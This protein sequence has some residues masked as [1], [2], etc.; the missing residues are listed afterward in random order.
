MAAK[1]MKKATKGKR[2]C[3]TRAGKLKKGWK[4]SKSRK[5]FCAPAKKKAAKKG[6]RK[7]AKRS[8]AAKK[9]A[10]T[11]KARSAAHH[12]AKFPIERSRE[13]ERLDVSKFTAEELKSFGYMRRR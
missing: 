13:P 6:K 11:R 3:L 8:A 5:G 7:S 9:A 2:G 1:K 10:A 12:E 4:W